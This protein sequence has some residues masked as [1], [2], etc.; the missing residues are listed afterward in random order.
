MILSDIFIGT[1]FWDQGILTLLGVKNVEWITSRVPDYGLNEAFMVFGGFALAFNVVTRLALC[2]NPTVFYIRL[3]ASFQLPQCLLSPEVGQEIRS[4][5][6]APTTT[7]PDYGRPPPPLA[8][9]SDL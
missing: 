7:L 2:N 3:I 6:V 4:H 9:L 5:S 8:L 1:Q